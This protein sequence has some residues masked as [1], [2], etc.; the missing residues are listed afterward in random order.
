MC[1]TKK[2]TFP[3]YNR[4]VQ[5]TINRRETN[6]SNYVAIFTEDFITDQS[7]INQWKAFLKRINLIDQL[8]YS[9]VMNVL[10]KFLKPIAEGIIEE[11]N[12][13]HKWN[14]DN[15]TWICNE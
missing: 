7:R 6:I 5:A 14:K 13:P 12:I 11:K 4:S 3:S 15:L 10:E 8:E 2:L 9:A 1:Y